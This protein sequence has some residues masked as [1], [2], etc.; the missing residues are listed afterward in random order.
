MF[1]VSVLQAWCSQHCDLLGNCVADLLTSRCPTASPSKRKRGQGKW[2]NTPKFSVCWDGA[3]AFLSIGQGLGSRSG[4][5]P[6]SAER[7]LGH[8]DR[9]RQGCKPMFK[10]ESMQRALQIAQAACTDTQRGL[11]SNLFALLEEEEPTTNI[12]KT[13]P[14]T[15]KGRGRK[16]TGSHNSTANTNSYSSK[17]RNASNRT[18]LKELSDSSESSSE[19]SGIDALNR[20]YEMIF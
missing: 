7:I 13:A 16:A 4:V 12:N 2:N 3:D 14:S 20:L 17:H 5:S 11:Y 9:A 18:S 8:L 19:V 10:V 6:P 15:S 1:V